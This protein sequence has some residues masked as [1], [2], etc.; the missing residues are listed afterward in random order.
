LQEDGAALLQLLPITPPVAAQLNGVN[1]PVDDL[2]INAL[3]LPPAAVVPP[4]LPLPPP[5]LPAAP[6]PPPD[7]LL[8]PHGVPWVVVDA[9]TEELHPDIHP[10]KSRL[11]WPMKKVEGDVESD[12]DYFYLMHPLDEV[13]LAVLGTNVQ[14]LSD[15]QRLNTRGELL[16]MYGIR[17]AACL[18]RRRGTMREMFM[19]GP[20][21]E[22]VLDYGNYA[23][24]F[25]MS[26][27]RFE[28]LNMCFRLRPPAVSE[29]DKADKWYM[30]R[31]FVGSYNKRRED[32]LVLGQYITVDES[33]SAWKAIS[34]E[35]KTDGC[36]H[37]VKIAR[38]PEG[39][40]VELKDA[41]DPSS[42]IIVHLEIQE[43]KLPMQA[44]EMSAELGAGAACTWRMVKAWHGTGRTIICDGWFGSYRCAFA[45][46]LVGLHIEGMVKTAHKCY[47][48]KYCKAWSDEQ[49]LLRDP[50]GK[51][52]PWGNHIVLVN[53]APNPTGGPEF[54]FYAL[55]HRD[56]KIKTIISTK[57]TTLP[58]RPMLVERVNIERDEQGQPVNHYYLKET[59]RC[60]MLETFFDNFSVIDVAN[61][62]RQGVIAVEKYWKT[63]S[64]WK[65]AFS[66]IGLGICL[67]DAYYAFR[68][69]WV[70]YHPDKPVTD[71]IDFAGRVAHSLIHNE[72]LQTPQQHR[73]AANLANQLAKEEQERLKRQPRVCS[74]LCMCSSTVLQY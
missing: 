34:G 3:E 8:N 1:V 40:G 36:P 41:A 49:N 11:V 39:V 17:L 15:K 32:V 20:R 18:E 7:P 53:K 51:K 52:I 43:G 70:K 47:P 30:I 56:R 71:V 62:K 6:L 23:E 35:F 9:V 67:C 10:Y 26:C 46:R 73:I 28:K 64:W 27:S 21:L 2:N 42:G 16:K 31:S 63:M 55:C 37:Q 29:A 33:M 12:V 19:S 54:T 69:D 58:G 59:P 74:Y 66:T 60:K 61:A 13:D 48:S 14:L 45:M 68:M 22:S 25:G 50:F 57:G 72:Y 65:R 44:K 24:R 38:K 4:A 5:P